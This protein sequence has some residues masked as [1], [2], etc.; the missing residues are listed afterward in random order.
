[1]AAAL[2]HASTSTAPVLLRTE[3]DVG[4]GARSVRRTAVLAGDELAFLAA[5]LGGMP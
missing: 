4:H 5:A 1:M 3:V 2:Q